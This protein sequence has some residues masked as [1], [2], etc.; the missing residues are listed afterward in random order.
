[1]DDIRVTARATHQELIGGKAGKITSRS[2]RTSFQKN[3]AATL[4]TIKAQGITDMEFS[5]LFG[6]TAPRPA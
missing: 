2:D 1:M 4:D 3:V 5:N 6:L